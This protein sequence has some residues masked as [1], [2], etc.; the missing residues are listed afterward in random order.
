MK[1]RNRVY[2]ADQRKTNTVASAYGYR[3]AVEENSIPVSEFS[4][5]NGVIILTKKGEPIMS[6]PIGEIRSS[7]N[8]DDF[9]EGA[10]KV[11]TRWFDS[12]DYCFRRL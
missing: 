4:A 3:T 2:T 12:K 1:E 9:D 8:D 11:G 7:I 6:G 10:I 5:G